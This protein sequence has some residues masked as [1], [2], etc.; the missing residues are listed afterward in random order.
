MD[1]TVLHC[2][3]NGFYASVELLIIPILKTFPW[4]Y[5]E[6]PKTATV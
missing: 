1:R 2:D 3:M 5:A 4:R 6:A